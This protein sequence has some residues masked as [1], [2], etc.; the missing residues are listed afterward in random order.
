M[1][2]LNKHDTVAELTRQIE[3]LEAQRDRLFQEEE[4]LE[5][6][7][8]Q[9]QAAAQPKVLL[10]DTIVT[11]GARTVLFPTV[12]PELQAEVIEWTLEGTGRVFRTKGPDHRLVIETAG[13]PKGS[14]R[15]TARIAPA[16]PASWAPAV[17]TVEPLQSDLDAV[18]DAL[19]DIAMADFMEHVEEAVSDAIVEGRLEAELLASVPD[20]E[21]SSRRVP[22]ARARRSPAGAGSS[23][24]VDRSTAQKRT[25]AR[26]TKATE[27][28]SSGRGTRGTSTK[29]QR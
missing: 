3:A 17:R 10:P 23:A 28:Q 26:S 12:A 8:V 5:Q 11:S 13:L 2:T 4:R 1:Q 22:V 16:S 20:A 6:K 24:P 29:Q 15:L 9:A 19:A 27:Q 7:L 25:L 21:A 14:Y 18:S